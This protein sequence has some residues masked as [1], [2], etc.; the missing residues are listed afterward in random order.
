MTVA[1]VF[2]A[3]RPRPRKNLRTDLS[4]TWV[5]NRTNTTQNEDLADPAA[6]P[7]IIGE[8]GADAVP[9]LAVLS[10]D[11]RS[12]APSVDSREPPFANSGFKED[13]ARYS[14]DGKWHAH[15]SN[16]SMGSQAGERSS[17]GHA[18]VSGRWR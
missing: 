4:P 5:Q 11:L 8:T 1:H 14:P 13:H 6:S 16:E 10:T 17:R 3:C 9:V 2:A 15:V 12:R 7:P 18:R